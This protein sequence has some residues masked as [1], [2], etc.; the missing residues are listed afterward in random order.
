MNLLYII[1]SREKNRVY[2]DLCR[3]FVHKNSL[4]KPNKSEKHINK[5]RYEQIKNYDDN[6]E[7]PEWLFKEQQ[8]KG[9][10]KPFHSKNP[11]KNQYNVISIHH[12]PSISILK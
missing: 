5:L 2:C 8:V 11:S 6:V 1:N 3:V 9:I 12:N 4:R 7:T 10:G